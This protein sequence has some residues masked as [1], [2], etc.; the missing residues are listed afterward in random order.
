MLAP[1]DEPPQCL[2]RTEFHAWAATQPLGRFE[3]IGSV[4]V[5]MAPER[6]VHARL[7]A[8]A[9]RL[10]R[11]SIR[12]RR[13]LT[14]EALPDGLTVEVGEDHD[15]IPDAMVRCGDRLPGDALAVNDPVIVVEV[16]SPSTAAIDRAVKLQA[17]FRLPSVQHYLIIAAAQRRVVHHR[18]AGEAITT[19]VH[20]A[21]W[22]DL[23]PPGLGLDVD[24][25]YSEAA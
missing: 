5:A 11:D 20:T 17:Y 18:R 22:I 24:A 4:V 10:L 1:I 2:S 23:N 9:W 6:A 14:C 19:G 15:F 16:L 25:L 12:D 8:S 7:K 21:G 3:R 13:L